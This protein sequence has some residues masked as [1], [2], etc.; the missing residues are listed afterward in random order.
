MA[1]SFAIVGF[2]SDIQDQTESQEYFTPKIIDHYPNIYKE[3]G[4]IIK[5]DYLYLHSVQ[6]ICFSEQFEQS[7]N[8]LPLETISE[9]S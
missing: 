7:K 2:S 5:E 1:H 3:N 9:L 6:S 8:K 4:E